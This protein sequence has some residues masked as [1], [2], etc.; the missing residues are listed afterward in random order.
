MQSDGIK[1]FGLVDGRMVVGLVGFCLRTLLCHGHGHVLN[2]IA[3]SIARVVSRLL[4]G[5]LSRLVV[6]SRLADRE[7]S[8]LLGAVLPRLVDGVVP[9]SVERV[10]PL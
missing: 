6:V 9:R 10:V 7:V 1:I 4:D 5:V 2:L 8:R 3:G